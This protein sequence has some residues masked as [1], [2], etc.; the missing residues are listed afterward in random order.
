M[1]PRHEA[2][3]QYLLDHIRPLLRN[4]KDPRLHTVIVW[5]HDYNDSLHRATIGLAL[6]SGAG[7]SPF[8][9]CAARQLVD[10]I[11]GPRLGP[12]L[13][14][15]FPDIKS[16]KPEATLPPP[17]IEKQWFTPAT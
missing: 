5:L 9:G 7:C 17:D 6:G 11:I 2:I 16:L 15:Q 12:E 1:D 13:K 10:E 3:Q 4:A 14:R 8:C